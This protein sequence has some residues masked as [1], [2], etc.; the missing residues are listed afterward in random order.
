MSLSR[1]LRRLPPNAL[2]L[3]G[4]LFLGQLAQTWKKMYHAG[5][6]NQWILEGVA[7]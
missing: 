6:R 4:F 2:Q 3:G 5:R 7:Y 1:R